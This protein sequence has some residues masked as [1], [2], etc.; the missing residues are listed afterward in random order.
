MISVYLLLAG[1]DKWCSGGIPS[2]DCH[3]VA[4]LIDCP[5]E[6]ARLTIALSHRLQTVR[7]TA[8]SVW[9][10]DFLWHFGSEQFVDCR[11]TDRKTDGRADGR[12]AMRCNEAP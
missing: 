10:L 2:T 3:L 4:I 6:F 9:Y 8:A 5:H 1:N 12:M 11:P 7:D